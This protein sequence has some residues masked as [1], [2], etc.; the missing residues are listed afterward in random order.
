M[1]ATKSGPW[2]GEQDELGPVKTPLGRQQR[3][4]QAATT[5]SAP[6]TGRCT[7]GPRNH[8]LMGLLR[9]QTQKSLPHV[10]VFQP[11]LS[12][13]RWLPMSYLWH[14]A[15]HNLKDG[16]AGYAGALTNSI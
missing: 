5:Q 3:S 12:L 8:F 13:G 2:V 15:P 6:M 7:Q 16:T 10:A 11:S 9:S 14:A 4:A 1:E